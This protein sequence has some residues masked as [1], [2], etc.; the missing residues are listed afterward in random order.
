MLDDVESS[1]D[2]LNKSTRFADVETLVK[3][4]N[5]K[6]FKPIKKDP[7]SEKTELIRK[8]SEVLKQSMIVLPAVTINSMK[9]Q[10][11]VNQLNKSLEPFFDRI[12]KIESP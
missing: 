8:N 1:F 9:D 6:Y 3:K 11:L 2:E 10:D 7:R 12:L 4:Y 5:E